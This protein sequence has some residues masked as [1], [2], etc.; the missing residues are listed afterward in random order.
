MSLSMLPL[1]YLLPVV[2]QCYIWQ[3]FRSSWKILDFFPK[4]SRPWKVWKCPGIYLWFI[5]HNDHSAEIGPPQRSSIAV[6]IEQKRLASGALPQTPWGSLQHSRCEGVSCPFLRP[7]PASALTFVDCSATLYIFSTG[8]SNFHLSLHLNITVLQ[9]R[10]GGP[11][12]VTI[13]WK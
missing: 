12:Q 9:Q 6:K 5:L 7:F 13:F 1:N 2:K 11:G 3:G 8:V 10:P 4:I